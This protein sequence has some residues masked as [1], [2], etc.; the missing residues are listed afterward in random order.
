MPGYRHTRYSAW[1]AVR[2]R[3]GVYPCLS[4]CDGCKDPAGVM[5]WLAENIQACLRDFLAGIASM[6]RKRHLASSARGFYG[7]CL[8]PA[9]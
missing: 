6:A 8:A 4:P 3:T 1:R 7:L 5:V 9:T 2:Q